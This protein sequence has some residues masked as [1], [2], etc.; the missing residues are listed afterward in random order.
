MTRV[1]CD[2]KMHQEQPKRR[3]RLETL[4]TRHMLQCLQV[5]VATMR[6]LCSV[7]GLRP[8][9]EGTRATVATLVPG[10]GQLALAGPGSVVQLFDTLR[11]RHVDRVQVGDAH[12]PFQLAMCP[13]P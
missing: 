3:G 7:H 9:V 12:S 8:R 13:F 2:C 6:V 11:D 1:L 5:N 10:S 4:I